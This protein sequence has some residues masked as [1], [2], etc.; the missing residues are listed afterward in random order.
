M[1]P[2]GAASSSRLP[3][4][5]ARSSTTTPSTSTSPACAESL[6]LFP[7]RRRSRRSTASA[8][9]CDEASTPSRRSYPS[10]ARRGRRRGVALV[11]GVAAF[12]LFLGQRLSAAPSRSRGRRRRPSVSS[13]EVVRTARL[14]APESPVEGAAV[15]SPFWVF[16]AT[17]ESRSR[18][19]RRPGRLPPRRSRADPS[20]RIRVE[21]S[22]R[23]YALPVVDG[24]KRA[25]YRGSRGLARS[26]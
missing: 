17:T 21:E 4:H 9:R 18:A 2:S 10:P 7:G 3:G 22:V 1:T 12:N 5:T 25:G 19:F 15:G 8:T 14:V 16:A 23:L 26:V 13:L 6:R 11:I 24:G 20:E